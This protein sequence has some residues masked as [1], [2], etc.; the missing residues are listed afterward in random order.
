MGVSGRL[1]GTSV[2]RCRALG[3]MP[4][5]PERHRHMRKTLSVFIPFVA[6]LGLAACGGVDRDGT[7]D[8]I[9]DSI[10]S[11]GGTADAGCIDDAL[12]Q[13]SDDE[14]TT[15]DD[16]L[17]SGSEPDAAASALLEDL[18]SCMTIDS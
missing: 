1:Y 2:R 3:P 14:L 10:E 18:M 11:V 16:A 4:N 8:M 17:G 15:I 13:Y 7:R 6:V 5:R 9:I 12:G